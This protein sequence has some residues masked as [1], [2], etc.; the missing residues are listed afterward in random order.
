MKITKWD[1]LGGMFAGDFF[2]PVGKD[3]MACNWT[4]AVDV[5]ETQ[6]KIVLTAELPGIHQ[7]DI[8]LTIHDDELMLRGHRRPE[9]DVQQENYHLLER[10]YGGF[11]RRFTMPCEVDSKNITANFKDGVLTV[12]IPKL[13]TT[14]KINVELTG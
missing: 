10:N 11:C 5:Y 14:K 4:P 12:T 1:P 13:S 3:E 7:E 2:G 8:E 6:G 9:K